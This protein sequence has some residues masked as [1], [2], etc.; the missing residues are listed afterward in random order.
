MRKP[1]SKKLRFEVFKRDFFKCQYCG[2]TPPGT[3]LEVD[4]V[5]PVSKNGS[6][7]IEN[8][9]TSCFDC[10]RGKSNNL[11]SAIPVSLNQKAELMKEKLA[12]VK[13]Y[14]K[15][16]KTIREYEESRIDFIQKIFLTYHEGYIFSEHFRKSVRLFLNKIDIHDVE[17]FMEFSCHKLTDKNDVIKYFC[18]MCWNKIRNQNAE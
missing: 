3:I 15:L 9:I 6:N 8:L 7:D 11:L 17:R 14:D 1:I 16:L 5:I 12:Q 10:N 18:G 4:H 2:N 13:A